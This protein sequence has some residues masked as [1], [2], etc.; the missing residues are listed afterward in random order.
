[1]LIA[2]ARISIGLILL[3]SWSLSSQIIVSDDFSDGDHSANPAWV[4]DTGFYGISTAGELQLLD[5]L[6]GSRSLSVASPISLK[7]VWEWSCQ[8]QFNPSSSNYL[9]VYLI[10]DRQD[11]GGA[12][13]GYFLD[14]GGSSDDVIS[15]YRQDGSQSTLLGKSTTGWVDISQVN[16]FVRVTR[17]K[18]HN[19]TVYADTANGGVMQQVITAHD[20]VYL[21]S[22]WFGLSPR[23]TKTRS[24]RFLFDDFVFTGHPYID[25][26]APT[27]SDLVVIDSI[28]L[29]V[30]L[31]ENVDTNSALDVANY[32]I[33]PAITVGSLKLLSEGAI[34]IELTS[35][36]I[37][38]KQ[39][40]LAISNIADWSGNRLDSVLMFRYTELIAG[41]IVINE[42]MI[43]PFPAVGI[44]PYDLPEA[45][46]IELH[47]LLPWEVKLIDWKLQVG[48][49]EYDLGSIA[50]DS[51][52]YLIISNQDVA[53]QFGDSLPM[54][55]LNIPLTALTNSGSSVSLSNA[56]GAIISSVNYDET[57]YQN[58]LKAQGGWSL[59]RINSIIK[60]N[61]QSN[62]SASTDVN[63]GTPGQMNSLDTSEYERTVPKLNT[64]FLNDQTSI[65]L[66]FSIAVPGSEEAFLNS[67]QI[68]PHLKILKIN[69]TPEDPSLLQIEFDEE[70]EN[71]RTYYAVLK[72]GWVACNGRIMQ[73]DTI[74]FGLPQL[75][76]FGDIQINELL[77]NPYPGGVD[78]VE[79]HNVSDKIVDVS[80]LRVGTWDSVTKSSINS[81]VLATDHELFFP[82]E[83]IT[84]SENVESLEANYPVSKGKRNLLAIDMPALPDNEGSIVIESTAMTLVDH[85]SYHE[86]MHHAL[87]SDPEGV[88]LEKISSDLATERKGNWHSA[89]SS[90]GYA[91]PGFRN[92]QSSTN[93]Q[94]G[95][96]SVWPKVF[97]PN[98]DGFNDILSVQYTSPKE[99]LIGKVSIWSYKGYLVKVLAEQVLMGKQEVFYWDG[100]DTRGILQSPGIYIVLLESFGL[101]EK[102]RIQRETCALS[103]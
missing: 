87:L 62:W 84:F 37:P 57:F 75:P 95:G 83:Y 73:A 64:L 7:A 89:A 14:L 59:E 54:L 74:L 67:L 50:L 3:T 33:A 60:C 46:Y 31:S 34:E 43:D 94:A 32:Q 58:K 39:Y 17:D 80:R 15:L 77:F 76:E 41:D 40:S 10:S 78:F 97:T 91:T 1:M 55:P 85:F 38:S 61:D 100:S 88:S 11:V 81:A 51:L 24:D 42:L 47:N 79:L 72:G 4:G 25:S 30:L 16:L 102:R 71:G 26:I 21:A 8:L 90:I 49:K 5:S 22:R 35:S 9:R 20:S 63:G 66:R 82:G 45:E 44:P 99:G 6:A 12:V 19:W 13:R 29:Y 48:S 70:L 52:G 86:D 18:Y 69:W 93:G 96:L 103:P 56:S 92:S 36:M 65:F 28:R 53:A 23:Y 27:I 101:D 2:R 68:T 98:M